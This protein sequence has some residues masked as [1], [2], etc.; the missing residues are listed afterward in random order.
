MSQ[1]VRSTGQKDPKSAS[2]HFRAQLSAALFAR[3]TQVS[4]AITHC[5]SSLQDVQ[6]T[7][8]DSR[9]NVKSTTRTLLALQS[10]ALKINGITIPRTRNIDKWP[11]A[12]Y[13]PADANR[14]E[15]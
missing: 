10:E 9:S 14:K 15:Q 13:T 4:T 5:E 7:I 6:K 1:S 2:D 11:T 3:L 8:E 12:V